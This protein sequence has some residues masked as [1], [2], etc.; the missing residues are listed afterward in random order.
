VT[1]QSGRIAS[2]GDRVGG[3]ADLSRCASQP[4]ALADLRA[5]A[6]AFRQKQIVEFDRLIA[7]ATAYR[8]DLDRTAFPGFTARA[9][10][11]NAAYAV[12]GGDEI[13][14]VWCTR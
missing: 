9:A 12:F 5:D 4:K 11:G 8:H 3:P 2:T 6:E 1:V 14:D 7:T 10:L 13:Y